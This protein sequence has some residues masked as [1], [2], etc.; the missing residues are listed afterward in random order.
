MGPGVRNSLF[1]RTNPNNSTNQSI[2]SPKSALKQQYT[3]PKPK[4]SLQ[5]NTNSIFQRTVNYYL[6]LQLLSCKYGIK[7]ILCNYAN[8]S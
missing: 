6:K 7:K 3:T 8:R 5:L 4:K 2:I 1:I